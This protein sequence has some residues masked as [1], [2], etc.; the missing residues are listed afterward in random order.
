MTEEHFEMVFGSLNPSLNK[1]TLTKETG[2]KILIEERRK[3]DNCTPNYS[4][5]NY[6]RRRIIPSVR[7]LPNFMVSGHPRSLRDLHIDL[8]DYK[9][10]YR[11]EHKTKQRAIQGLQI[12]S[13]QRALQRRKYQEKDQGKQVV[14]TNEDDKKEECIILYYIY[15]FILHCLAVLTLCVLGIWVAVA[16]VVVGHVGK[17]T[18]NIYRNDNNDS[19]DNNN[20]SNDSNDSNDNNN[21]GHNNNNSNDNNNSNNNNNSND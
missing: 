14:R 20:N 4:K 10:Q 1:K 7:R 21:I 6:S 5:T 9:E 19:N 16:S 3:N 11:D 17:V 18:I 8:S 12:I 15:I 13:G 2:R